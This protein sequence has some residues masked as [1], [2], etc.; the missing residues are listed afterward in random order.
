MIT[1]IYHQSTK[2]QDSFNMKRLLLVIAT[3]LL[4]TTVASE[5]E[6]TSFH[7]NFAIEKYSHLGSDYVAIQSPLAVSDNNN[8]SYKVTVYVRHETNEPTAR[9]QVKL[10]VTE[11][12]GK[13][14]FSLGRANG[15]VALHDVYKPS[16]RVY[17]VDW[18]FKTFTRE[19]NSVGPISHLPRDLIVDRY[20][21][22][23]KE[24]DM[25]QLE[26]TFV[27]CV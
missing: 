18:A 26:V 24:K 19:D 22:Y 13:D 23:D 2:Y 21:W 16:S 7:L 3:F 27:C 12:S 14:N 6:P 25:V 1:H 4:L 11:D 8:D 17:Y 9:L 5:R 15:L 20:F 10:V